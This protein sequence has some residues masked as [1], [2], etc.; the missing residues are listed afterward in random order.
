MFA[1]PNI[2]VSIPHEKYLVTTGGVVLRVHGVTLTNN[3]VQV[4]SM[5]KTWLVSTEF[6]YR[7]SLFWAPIIRILNAYTIRINWEILWIQ[8]QIQ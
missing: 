4:Y 5:H 8:K 6:L 1:S 2:N 3:H 7:S